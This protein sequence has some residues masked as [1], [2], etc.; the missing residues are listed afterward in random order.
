MKK[1]LKKRLSLLLVMAMMITL[2]I[3]FTVTTVSAETD[4]DGY[5]LI[6]SQA[7]FANIANGTKDSDGKV[8][9]KYKL[10]NDI[11]ISGTWNFTTIFRGELHGNGKTI[12]FANG[13][14]ITGG[15]FKMVSANAYIHDLYIVQA[16][17][18]TW[19]PQTADGCVQA[20]LGA[21]AG[22]AGAGVVNG[23]NSWGNESYV[24][25][26]AN[27]V[28][29][30]NIHVTA[31]IDVS[32]SATGVSVGGIVGELGI[33]TEVTNCVFNGY[34]KDATNRSDTSSQDNG[35]KRSGY[36]GIVGLTFRRGVL[37]MT[38]CVN[39]GN[40][41][42]YGQ[43]GGIL[44][45]ANPAWNAGDP[46]KTV[47]VQKC[48]NRGT[49]TCSNT[50]NTGSVG[51]IVGYL[52]A[53][54][55]NGA[56]CSVLN[57]INYGKIARASGSAY[58]GGI[59]GRQNSK[60]G[61]NTILY[62]GNVQWSSDIGGGSQI[63]G[64]QDG[65]G[66]AVTYTNNFGTGAGDSSTYSQLNGSTYT[67]LNSAYSGIYALYGATGG[68][69]VGLQIEHGSSSGIG[70]ATANIASEGDL[71]A[72]L[73]RGSGT[74][75]LTADITIH[76]SWN[77]DVVFTGTL[78][79][80]GH[81]ITFEKGI[82]VT[83]GLFRQLSS[84][85]NINNLKIVQGGYLLWMPVAPDGSGA[86]CVGAVA[87][88]I[89]VPDDCN[90]TEITAVAANTVYI[91][92]VT[93]TANINAI[94]TIDNSK[95]YA[96]GGLIGE[97]GM[98]TS[99]S[100]CTFNGSIS[101]VARTKADSGKYESGYG[102]IIGVQIRNGGP[103]TISQCINNGSITGYAC[104]G[105][106]LGHAREWGGGATAP[107]GITLEKCINNG[108]ISG[109]ANNN[110]A[111]VGGIAG[112]VYA[113]NAATAIVRYCINSSTAVI[114]SN[115]TTYAGGIVGAIRRNG[116]N[117]QFIG[118]L[119]ESD[120]IVGA[121]MT[122]AQ[123][124]SGDYYVNNY[125][126]GA[127][128]TS[129]YSPLSYVKNYA[130]AWGVLNAAYPGIFVFRN[131][132]VALK[133]NDTLNT[134]STITTIKGVQ[135]SNISNGKRSIRF[136]AGITDD[137]SVT[138]VGMEI[139]VFYGASGAAGTVTGTTASVHSSINANG[140]R[141]TAASLSSAYLYTA[142]VKNAPTSAGTITILVRTFHDKGGNRYYSEYSYSS[143]NL[144]S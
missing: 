75:T 116:T 141:Q 142:V 144:A 24:S 82:T 127:G 77:N 72:A 71:L 87:A 96:V 6:T 27:K 42:G 95:G 76:N 33:Y 2:I 41:T 49:I 5:T 91:Q 126:R 46:F 80:G 84:K 34:I 54:R 111:S 61:T 114:A 22:L 98:I 40:V 25:N 36:G 73:S 4:S 139:T 110:K 60:S 97:S 83:G 74:Y 43:V 16:G 88:S 109:L 32:G 92:N 21:V 18:A 48:V 37:V 131:N 118:N 132:K 35:S 119:Q 56:T 63:R 12:T 113:K 30:E 62:R 122:Q 23:A 102:G 101:D 117:F 94:Y 115:L 124:G 136:V 50:A 79:G 68:T 66:S 64:Q 106:I 14:S 19:T 51:G 107:A 123:D 55:Q 108:A 103:L 8:T 81:T 3:P 9:G 112:Y 1:V 100:G 120:S 31:M 99:I 137:L 15:L 121:Q 29:F 125:G 26:S 90:N 58:I 13:A 138:D 89:E 70:S 133:W 140:S 67:T 20:C 7:D 93:V 45:S 38:G 52:Y 28:R 69:R 44:G 10:K 104:E 134:T 128:G 57:N 78:N 59:T 105:G 130:D 65:D 86:Y 129:V 17:S 135:L 85:A 53:A 39:N 11:T 143:L 47:T